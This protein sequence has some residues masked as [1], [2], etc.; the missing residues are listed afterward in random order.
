MK[1]IT[2]GNRA[3]VTLKLITTTIK[4]LAKDKDIEQSIWIGFVILMIVTVFASLGWNSFWFGW[5][6]ILLTIINN[7]SIICR[8]LL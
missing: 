4:E 8:V 6:S 2:L 3:E 7:L 5:V 1:Y